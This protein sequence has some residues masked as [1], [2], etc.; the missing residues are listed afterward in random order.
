[1]KHIHL[2]TITDSK[3][4]K[5]YIKLFT[6][7]AKAVSH[8]TDIG[9]KTSGGVIYVSKSSPELSAFIDKTEVN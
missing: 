8:L 2:V 7:N 6:S 5:S 4:K 3:T 1:M 9:F